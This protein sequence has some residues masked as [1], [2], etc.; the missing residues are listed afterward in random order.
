MNP[1]NSAFP[2][3]HDMYGSTQDGISIRDYIAIEV[4]KGIISN[5]TEGFQSMISKV[6]EKRELITEEYLAKLAYVQADALIKES[7][8]I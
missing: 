4:L 7:K 6:A 3:E 2:I 1:K 5:S 8:N